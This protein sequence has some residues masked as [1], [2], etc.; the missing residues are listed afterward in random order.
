MDDKK[1]I[2]LAREYYSGIDN[3]TDEEV[4]Q[5]IETRKRIKVEMIKLFFPEIKEEDI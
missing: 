5:Y 3:F 4:L 2:E 1:K